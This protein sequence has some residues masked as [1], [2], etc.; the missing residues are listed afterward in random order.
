MGFLLTTSTEGRD[1]PFQARISRRYWPRS[2]ALWGHPTPLLCRRESDC[3]SQSLSLDF[4]V[5]ITP[6]SIFLPMLGIVGDLLL[7]WGPLFHTHT[8]TIGPAWRKKL[9]SNNPISYWEPDWYRNYLLTSD[10]KRRQRMKMTEPR[11]PLRG[12]RAATV[13]C[14]KRSLWMV[15]LSQCQTPGQ[16]FKI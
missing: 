12:W 7:P 15:W 6:L 11:S 5:L 13:K 2:A 8:L 4:W 16:A 10:L 3:T 14:R 1:Q 9:S